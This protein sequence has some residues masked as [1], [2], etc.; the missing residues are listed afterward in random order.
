M[1][2]SGI[3]SSIEK[4]QAKKCP[5]SVISEIS[6]ISYSSEVDANVNL[7]DKACDISEVTSCNKMNECFFSSTC[8]QFINQYIDLFIKLIN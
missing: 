7:D 1:K 4:I 6:E 3:H 8:N 2:I 5:K